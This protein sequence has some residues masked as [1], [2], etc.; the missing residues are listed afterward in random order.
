M[1]LSRLALMRGMNSAL[2]ARQMSPMSPMTIARAVL[3]KMNL[4]LHR[5]PCNN[6]RS[7]QAEALSALVSSGSHSLLADCVTEQP[8]EV[9]VGPRQDRDDEAVRFLGDLEFPIQAD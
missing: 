3:Q 7:R 5:E 8:T 2:T 4:V 9:S 1:R 6:H